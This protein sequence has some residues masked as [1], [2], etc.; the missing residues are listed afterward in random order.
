M[1]QVNDDPAIV[2]SSIRG[3]QS[4]VDT[5]VFRLGEHALD[6]VEVTYLGDQADLFS[7]NKLKTIDDKL[8]V[9]VQFTPSMEFIGLA[10]AVM[11]IKLGD[12]LLASR[13]VR[14]LSTKA[15][16][17]ENEPSLALVVEAM[18]WKIDLGWT[19]L[20]NHTRAELQGDELPVTHF[21][22][23]AGAEMV[24]MVPVARYS[25]PFA[26]PFG[27][28]ETGNDVPDLEQVGV[29]A[30][31]TSYPEHQTLY[32]SLQEGQS[33]FDP[34]KLSFGFY[35]TSPSHVA[36]SEDHWNQ[37]LHPD[38]AV[39]ACRVYTVKDNNGEVL[40]EQYLV[41]FEEAANGDYQDYVFLV[42]HVIAE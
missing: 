37:S 29:L 16:E 5:V 40:P 21:R 19:R 34:G 6:K 8:I 11:E 10:E 24:E 18:G 26:L 12:E 15:L 32:P 28:Y 2:L 4:K 39:H 36:Y 23:A 9:S 30:N 17:G 7:T 27:Y 33:S 38:H 1:A 41:C 25:P 31:S 14:G 22:K 13:P 20:A 3:E 42:K 35:T